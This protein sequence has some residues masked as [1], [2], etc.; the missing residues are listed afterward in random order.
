MAQVHLSVAVLTTD[1]I[2]EK[3]R[4]DAVP[5]LPKELQDLIV[6]FVVQGMVETKDGSTVCAV[7]HTSSLFRLRAA[8]AFDAI[9]LFE[10]EYEGYEKEQKVNLERSLGTFVGDVIESWWL[11]DVSIK[12]HRVKEPVFRGGAR[13][14]RTTQGRYIASGGW[15]LIINDLDGTIDQAEEGNEGTTDRGESTEGDLYQQEAGDGRLKHLI[16]RDI[17]E[18]LMILL[19]TAIPPRALSVFQRARCGTL[20]VPSEGTF[21]EP[22]MVLHL[23][24]VGAEGY[25]QVGPGFYDPS[26]L[27]DCSRCWRFDTVEFRDV[28]T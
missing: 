9:P 25:S 19:R 26:N 23:A 17:V 3:K 13:M 15:D 2:S 11:L 21:I 22:Q 27:T 12:R 8:Q 18:A 4:K 20:K 10:A 16:T 7:M 24:E 28:A 14:L 5:E 1:C 6:D